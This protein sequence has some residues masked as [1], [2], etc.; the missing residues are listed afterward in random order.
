M[1]DP[2]IHYLNFGAFGACA[3]PVF[4]E[5]QR[6]QRMLEFQPT[7]F[8]MQTGPALLDESKSLLA[9]YI[10]TKK[11]NIVY[12]TNPTFGV[13]VIAN[14][15][16]LE[17]GDEILSTNLE[18][19]ACDKTWE[20]FSESK[21]LRYVKQDIELPLTSKEH[22]LT[23][24]WK[25]CTDKTKVVFISHVTS[26]TA[27]RLPVEE[28]CIEAKKRGLITIVD[29]A[30]VPGHIP[31]DLEFID[32]D[33]Y[34]GACHKWM[35]TPKGSSFLVVKE[36]FQE[37]IRPFVVSW[38][39]NAASSLGSTFLDLHTFIGTRDFTPFLTI[40]AALQFMKEHH[41]E[42]VATSCRKTT[43]AFLNEV[44]EMVGSQPLAPV[45]DDFILQMGSI[46]ILCEKPAEVKNFLL[47]SR[48]LEL[49]VF[50]QN[51][52]VYVRYSFNGFNSANDLEA[53]SNALKELIDDKSIQ[54]TL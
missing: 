48:N 39:Y 11:E 8:I 7:E 16:Q 52:N 32:C 23:S 17:E 24:F 46:P 40:P 53:L 43:Q 6:L 29:G 45:S 42:E 51:N 33:F 22:F 13:N 20:Y 15:L 37:M 47:K 27:L 54:G 12:I 36:R 2:Q 38:G 5:Y 10:G 26:M 3:L 28:I 25:G 9:S 35:M 50:T 14:S 49:P 1:L 41:W 19:G 44:C 30:H 18:Y 34:V 4:N 21:N 31:I